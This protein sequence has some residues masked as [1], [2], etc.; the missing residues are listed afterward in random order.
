MTKLCPLKTKQFFTLM[1][2]FLLSAGSLFAQTP[3]PRG[4][5]V[6][7]ATPVTNPMDPNGDGFIFKP[8]IPFSNDGYYVDEFEYKMF[9]IPKVGGDV[10][11]DNQTGPSCGMSDLIPDLYN[12]NPADPLSGYGAYAYKDNNNNLIF[13]FRLGDAAN[14]VNSWHILLDTDGKY[15]MGKDPNATDSNPGFEIDITLINKQSPGVFVTNI[16]GSSGCPNPVLFYPLSSNFQ[17]SVGDLVTCGDPD[18]F[19]DFYVPFADIVTQ[20]GA[21]LNIDINTGL[22]YVAST[23]NSATCS[24]S[25]S[26]ADISGVNNNNAPYVGCDLCAYTELIDSQCPTAVAQLCQT[27]E[28]FNTG[29]ATKPTIKDVNVGDL[30]V[31]GT[32]EGAFVKLSVYSNTNPDAP[33]TPPTW[34]LTT[35]REFHTVAVTA[36]TWTVNLN[37][38][39]LPYD[40]I[41][42]QTQLTIDGSSVCDAIG[43]NSSTSTTIVSN[44]KPVAVDDAVTTN[45]D[46]VVTFSVTANDT[47][48]DGNNTIN[49]ASVDLNPATAIEDKTYTVTG[50]GTYTVDNLGN[51]TFTPVANYN[52]IATP[53]T[54]TIKDNQGALS[55]VAQIQVTVTPVNDA[56]VANNQSVTTN[57]DTPLPIILTATD[58]DGNPLTYAIVSSPQHGT[59]SVIVGAGVTY[60][61]AANYFGSDSFTFTAFDGTALSNVATVLITVASVND[62][63]VANNVSVTTNEDVAVII[64]LSA[65]DIENN[66][67]TY[68]IVT[69]PA[70]GTLSG[71]GANPTYT[72]VANYNGADSFTYKAN[73]GTDS[74]IA[75]VNITINAVNDA[76]VASSQSVTTNEDTPIGITLTATDVDAGTTLSY[77]VV[78]APKFGTLSCSNCSNPTYTPNANFYGEDSFTFK[79]NDGIVDSN[80]ATVTITVDPVPDAPVAYD[81][82]VNTNEDTPVSFTIAGSDPDGNPI[83]YTIVSS[84]ANGTLSGTAPGLTFTPALNFNGVTTFTFKVNDGTFDSNIATVTINVAAVN[85]APIAN[86]QS[87][88]TAEDTPVAITLTGSDVDG[89]PLTYTIV[90]SPTKG[91]LGVLSGAGVT[92]T[93]NA[94]YNGSD[95]FTFTVNDGAITSLPATV[96]ITVTAVNDIPVANAQSVTVTEDVAKTITLTGS[97]IETPSASLTFS[98]ATPP[99]NGTLS[100]TNCS[101]PVYTPALN[102]NGADSFTFTVNDGTATSTAATVSITVNAVNDAP[103]ANNQ[104]VTTAEDTPV[105]ITLTGSD[106]DGNPLTYTIAS[107]P[108]KGTLGVLSGAGVTYTPNANYNGSD[109]F[110]FTVND[111][112]ITSLPATVSITVTAVNDIPVANAQSVTVTEDVAKTITLTGSDIETPSASLTFS[113]ATPPSNGTLSCTNCSNPVYTPA[114]NYNGADSFTFT[115]NDGTAT[116]L[117]ATVSITVNAVNDTPVADNQTVST[118][119]DTALPITLTAVDVDGNPL[120]YSIV[121][122]PAHGTLSAVSGAGVTYT[123]AANYFGPDN[124]VFKV[125]DGT[126]FSNDASV[127][128]TVLPVNDKP[129]ASN[130]TSTTNEDVPVAITLVGSDIDGDPLTYVITVGPLHGTLSGSGANL[131]YY[132][133]LNYNGSDN[134]TYVVND[135][136]I[137]S[138]PAT[139]TI[140]INAINDLP[141]ANNTTVFY[142]L[143]T[144]VNFTLDT[145]DAESDALTYSTLSLPNPATEGTVAGTSPNLSYMPFN[146][147]TG[148]STMTFKVNDGTGDSDIAT[149]TFVFNSASNDPPVAQ[150]QLVTIQEDQSKALILVATDADPGDVLTYSIVSAPTHGTLSCTNCSNP[151]YTPFANYFGSDS[152]VFRATD[153]ASAYDE[154]TVTITIVSVD[155][156]PVAN[157]QAVTVTEDTPKVITLTGSDVE[158]ATASLIYANTTPLHGSLSCTNCANPTYTPNLNYNGA[159]SFSFTVNDGAITSSPAIV[160]ITVSPVNDAP[161]ANGQTLNTDE[162]TP[163]PI[164]LT[165]TDVEGSTLT[166]AS[167]IPANGTLSCY[168]CATPVYTPVANFNGSD[169]FT[170]TVRDGALTSNTATVS[171]TVNPINDT[172]IANAQSVTVAEDGSVAIILTGSDVEGSV[173][174]FASGLPSH[175]T[176]SCTNC[177]NPVYSPAL[178]YNGSDSFTFTVNDGALTSIAATV[179]I[180]V[181]PVNDVPVADAQSVTTDEDTPVAI[182]LSGSDIDLDA[183]TYE[184][185]TAP[186]QGTLSCNN[187]INPIYTPSA[188]YHGA[189]SFTFRVKDANNAYSPAVTVSITINAVNDTPIANPQSVTVAED[190]SATIILT[191][192]DVEGSTLTFASGLPSHGTLSCTDC[193]NPVYT[194]EPNFNGSDSFTFT[195]NDGA[196]TSSAATVSIT[197][198]PV[199]D[200]PVANAQSITT[201]EDTPVT[202]TLSGSDIDQNA[203]TYAVVIPPA[204]GT[205]SCN[206]CANPVYTPSTNYNGADSFT[207]TVN[208]GTLNSEVATISVTVNAVNDAP[209]ANSQSVTVAEDGSVTITLIGSDVEGSSLTFASGLPSHGALSCTDCSSP[210]YTPDANYNGQDSFT[211]TV[212][213]GTVNSNTATVS[214]NVTPVNDVPVATNDINITTLEDNSVPFSVTNNDIDIDGTIDPLT[215]DLDPTTLVEDKILTVTGQGVY[216][217]DNNGNVTFTPELNYNG[218]ASS[219]S[220]TVRDNSGALSNTGTIQLIV[221]PVNDAP[222]VTS[223]T[224]TI[225]EDETTTICFTVSDV[226]NDP[227]LFSG[228]TSMDG[229]GSLVLDKINDPYCFIYTPNPNI[230]GQDRVEVTVCDTKDPGLCSTGVITIII[231]PVNDAPVILVGGNP[232]STITTT[233]PEDT[234]L[235]FCFDADDLEGDNIHVGSIANTSG[236]GTLVSGT[237]GG[238]NNFCFTF[239]PDQNFNG[240]SIWTVQ[241]CDD[242]NP[243]LCKTLTVE[244]TVTPV[245]DAPVASNQTVTVMEDT[246]KAITLVATDTDGDPLTYTI[247][248]NPAYGTLTG[249]GA[250]LTYTPDPN[251]NGNDTVTFKVNDGTVDSNIATIYINVTAVNDAPVIAFIPVLTTPEDTE[252]PVCLGV[253]DVD[254]DIVTNQTPINISGGGTMTPSTLLDFCYVFKPAQDFNGSSFWKFTVCDNANPSLCGEIIV[255]IIVTPVNDAPVAVNDYL[256]AQSYVKIAPVNILANDIDVDNDP[257]VLTTTALSGPFNGSI[258]MNADGFFEYQSKLGFIGSDSVRYQVCDSGTPSLCDEAVVFIEVGPAPFKIYQGLSPNNDGLNDYWRIDG[259]EMY[260]NNHVQVFDRFNNLIY[261]TKGYDNADNNWRG[262]TNHGLINGNLPEGTYYYSVNLGDGSD[263]FSGYVVLKKN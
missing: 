110:T 235:D 97:D 84:P 1:A 14:S 99:S 3:D 118:N 143:N 261:Q 115:V 75:T 116:S 160:S 229:K 167:S 137:D 148:T 49:V 202:I 47:D 43:S 111:G 147:Y 98:I 246:P 156:T 21:L 135:G 188:N 51:V 55:N 251:Y 133:N 85:D 66:P 17:M 252:H 203:L 236:G 50:Q 161:V 224:V 101:N 125:F 190:G 8:G 233:T 248:N 57:E 123:P 174:T 186:T 95:S 175:G 145:Y 16:D 222:V 141:V 198:T 27:C 26:A 38:P 209:V 152:F 121:T 20:L 192:S 41:I 132:P 106:V 177:S 37:S 150:D 193:F 127:T 169:S 254:G 172:P 9:G 163:L 176:L 194:P 126:V 253:K 68:I 230:N 78:V 218:T 120:T 139:G 138:D 151:T 96:S 48:Q 5:I 87:V 215:V 181:T 249:T 67:L 216:S 59:L 185:V 102:Y 82:T 170:F 210:V 165:G 256:T 200:R 92:Y 69:Q 74:N 191:G 240:V 33:T 238:V 72:P 40:K 245:Q 19:F 243:S 2:V 65:T 13:R 53:I 93:P 86:N 144:L 44:Y 108:T 166:F 117:A 220:Y 142:E 244:I 90:S 22:R 70:H 197:V 237:S 206:N 46:V 255:Q 31:A 225:N 196:L 241:V 34:N 107:L 114:L 71:S 134:F 119:E 24:M 76:P 228:G 164:T 15:G 242:G 12:G 146:N 214:I 213:D 182:T 52:G 73:D 104:N 113:I 258:K 221:T 223:T 54:Y 168:N 217:V 30:L 173:L 189:D 231:A 4:T 94:N 262:Q 6:T 136:T 91:T 263:L 131:T 63:P 7:P 83:T 77:S 162:D 100:C 149:V 205:L 207:F 180:T 124:F 232:A 184:V 227:T 211:F 122:G 10:A 250:N 239:T 28:G 257:L 35:P 23:S 42:A 62:A 61:P 39:L 208:D 80:I 128:I 154:G 259:I 56:P 155:D 58:V 11:N 29:I 201:D 112:A 247:I 204:H 103:I 88:T 81:L 18:Y 260:P 109:S 234:P 183:L 36:K 226:E 158:T 195:V 130:I 171:I 25:G 219:I 199:N 105:A 157:P 60:T 140:T 212:H 187:C 32:S 153:I 79:A 129:T 64:P 159:D 45:E 179:T 89:N 178:N